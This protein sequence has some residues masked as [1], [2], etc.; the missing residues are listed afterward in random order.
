MHDQKH[1]VA[2]HAPLEGKRSQVTCPTAPQHIGTWTLLLMLQT[3]CRRCSGYGLLDNV[4]VT[5]TEVCVAL[6]LTVL[7][8]SQQCS[9]NMTRSCPHVWSLCSEHSAGSHAFL[10]KHVPC[11]QLPCRMCLGR[12]GAHMQKTPYY[13]LSLSSRLT[14]VLSLRY[15]ARALSRLFLFGANLG[16]SK[17]IR[18]HELPASS[19]CC[20][21]LAM[22]SFRK[23][24]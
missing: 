11:L 14:R 3:T 21:Y 12:C 19:C 5:Q 10:T 17:T 16:G 9:A 8:K 18:S 4:E 20:M 24:Y 2:S 13:F 7:P 6:S 15:L 1:K 23:V 22:S